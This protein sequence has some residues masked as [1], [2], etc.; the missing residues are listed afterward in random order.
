MADT[1]GSVAN[2]PP[3]ATLRLFAPEHWTRFAWL[4]RAF[5]ASFPDGGPARRGLRIIVDHQARFEQLHGLWRGLR[6]G[7]EHDIAVFQRQGYSTMEF[8]HQY[9]AL[10]EVLFSEQYAQMDGVRKLIFGR[11]R[12]VHGVQDRTNELLFSR[13]VENGYGPEIPPPVIAA[14]RTAGTTWFPQLRAIRTQV[15]HGEVGSCRLDGDAVRYSLPQAGVAIE[16]VEQVLQQF[17]HGIAELLDSMASHWLTELTRQD[18]MVPCLLHEGRMYPR[19][20]EV[21]EVVPD[22]HS[23]L[24][25]FRD[26]FDNGLPPCPLRERCGAYAAS[27]GRTDEIRERMARISRMS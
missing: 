12:N 3:F 15:T 8:S 27:E 7:L 14:L 9:A 19:I 26:S 5:G 25:G 23:G 1:S 6:V 16:D 24:C 20:L 17:S 18:I 21:S 2:T 22:F 13:A 10:T 11:Y 4:N